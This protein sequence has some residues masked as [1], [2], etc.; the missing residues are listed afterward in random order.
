MDDERKDG[1][2]LRFLIKLP[3]RYL[4]FIVLSEILVLYAIT[5][6]TEIFQLLVIV[7]GAIIALSQK[8]AEPQ[9]IDNSVNADVIKT[10]QVH[11][12]TMPGAQIT[13]EK[14]KK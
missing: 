12:D 14:E 3:D 7:V 2:F 6:L 10:P 11:A 4:L 9:G 8:K 1:S 13:V 5:R